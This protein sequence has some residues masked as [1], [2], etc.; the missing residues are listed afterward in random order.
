V[1]KQVRQELSSRSFVVEFYAKETG[2]SPRDQF[3]KKVRID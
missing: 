1:A 2:P 3:L